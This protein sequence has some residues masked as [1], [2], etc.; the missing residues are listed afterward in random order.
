MTY[1]EI[2]KLNQTWSEVSAIAEEMVKKYG[3]DKMGYFQNL[4]KAY[5]LGVES[6]SK[7]LETK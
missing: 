2:I 7:L 4:M 5:S 1:E 6:A 3:G